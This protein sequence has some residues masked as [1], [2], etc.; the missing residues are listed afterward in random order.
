MWGK[1]NIAKR[2]TVTKELVRHFKAIKVPCSGWHIKLEQE[3]NKKHVTQ[4]K[5]RVFY[6]FI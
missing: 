6:L 1:E 2:A 4:Q 5:P 3:I